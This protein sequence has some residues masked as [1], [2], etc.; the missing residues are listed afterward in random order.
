M[1]K[2]LLIATLSFIVTLTAQTPPKVSF[3]TDVQPIFRQNC[4]GCHGPSAQQAGL[5]LDRK[6][7]VMKSFSR[8]VVPGNSA[9]SFVYHR[10]ADTEYGSQMPPTGP[11]RPDQIATVKAWIDQGADWPASLANELDLPPENRLATDIVKSLSANAISTAFEIAAQDPTA[12][13]ARGPG[14][15]TPFMYAVL[16]SNADTL[17]RF[18]K[19]GADPNKRNDVG[20]TALMWA[21]KDIDK[22]R[23]LLDNRADVNAKSADFR[24]PLM[25]AARRFGGKAIVKL[26]LDKGVNPNPNAKPAT[27]SS[28]LLEALT[29]GDPDIVELLIK[30]GANVEATADIGLTLAV[31]LN[32]E[33]CLNL[34]KEKITDKGAY[35]LALQS[36]AVFGDIKATRLM[37]DKGADVNAFDPLGRTPL[38]YAA[39][40]DLLP[41]DVVRLLIERGADVNAIDR[42]AKSGDAG[43]SVLDIAHFNG[44]TPVA[45]LLVSAGAK[46]TPQTPLALK[47]KRDNTIQAAVKASLPLVQ[48]A[49]AAFTANSGCI[50]C[51]NNSL[52]AMSVSLAR[53]RGFP[54]NEDVAAAQ[55]QTNVKFLESNRDKLHQGAIFPVGDTVGEFILAFL[56]IGL[57]AEGYKPDLNTDAAAMYILSRQ[58]PNGE[59]LSPAADTRPPICL[60][61]IGQ[62]VLSMRALQLYA[63]K[64]NHA[65][66]EKAI[67]LTASWLAKVQ[68]Q[69]NEDR[70]WR[71]AGLAW[72]ATDRPAT[73]KA[74][75]EL[76]AAQRSDGGW[77]D[78]P[79][80]PSSSYA[81]GKSLAAL[82]IAAFPTSDA[83]YQRGLKFLLNT[84]LE[85]GS[86]YTKTR[87]LGF[88]PFFDANF[89]HGYDQWVSAAGTSW[90]AIALTLSLPEGSI[91]AAR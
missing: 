73:Q 70:S 12:I 9:N 22:T 57:E 11:L 42:H 89:P 51:H 44:D 78:L 10:I 47:F 33:K 5:R 85:D 83:A 90:A 79:T 25:I 61:Y 26:L 59:W 20:A 50:S 32:C 55:V 67:K 18:L 71:V 21:A 68:S 54:I 24:T 19:L 63:P 28:P 72:A 2:N 46:A 62:S 30:R 86:W 1:T 35:T 27:E 16:Y 4:V 36:T 43:K 64:T 81:T 56:L 65:A 88:Q 38:M 29:A 34:L 37:L 8:R 41:V 60:T 77:A 7:S 15:S 13:N 80:L 69:S 91:I 17:A 84:Q 66:Y 6:S 45:Q 74:I 52:A 75:A 40:S 3:A 14:G 49:D 53:K 39:I 48:R 23:L 82:R 31:Q 87:A 76:L 58:R